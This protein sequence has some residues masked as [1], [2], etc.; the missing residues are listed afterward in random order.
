VIGIEKPS[1]CPELREYIRF[2]GMTLYG[3]ARET[4]D[5]STKNRK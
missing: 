3:Q 5:R 1:H 2:E 4:M